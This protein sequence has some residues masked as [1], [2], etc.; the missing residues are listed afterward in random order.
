MKLQQCFQW[1]R[2]GLT[3]VPPSAPG[4]LLHGFPSLLTHYLWNELL[5]LSAGHI[6]FL[7]FIL[8]LIMSFFSPAHPL[9][10]NL[11]CLSFGFPSATKTEIFHE[12]KCQPWQCFNEE[13]EFCKQ[14]DDLEN[15]WKQTKRRTSSFLQ[16]TSFLPSLFK[17][18]HLHFKI[19]RCLCA[20]S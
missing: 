16:C 12:K 2:R 9:W 10:F 19:L 1:N 4:A 7:G 18:Q 3:V 20:A 11:R 14:R 5:Q 17:C 15:K 8:S 6:D 13:Y